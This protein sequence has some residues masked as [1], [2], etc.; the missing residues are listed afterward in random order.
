MV[1]ASAILP[2]SPRPHLSPRENLSMISWQRK[3]KMKSSF[4]EGS[5]WPASTTGK[6]TAAA[7]SPLLGYPWRAVVKRN[8]PSR[9]NFKQYTWLLTLL[10]RRNDQMCDYV[11]VHD[12]WL[13]VWLN[14]QGIGWNMIG[15][16]VTR[17]FGEEI[18]GKT[19][20]NGQKMWRCLCPMWILP[21]EWPQWRKIS[22]V[23][24]IG[25]SILG[26]QFSLFS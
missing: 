13:M 3:K 21:E 18:C 10:E 16:L 14:G 20:P 24:W 26:I 2:L 6:W 4:R 7:L 9:Q 19:S 25:W 8:P 12:L 5:S 22:I 11:A 23:K 1:E 17:K 15:K